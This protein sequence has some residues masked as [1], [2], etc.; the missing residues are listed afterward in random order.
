MVYSPC[1]VLQFWYV[2][3]CSCGWVLFSEKLVKGKGY[4]IISFLLFG[5]YTGSGKEGDSA[6]C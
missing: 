6:H 4:S 3:D 2:F 1:D 5:E